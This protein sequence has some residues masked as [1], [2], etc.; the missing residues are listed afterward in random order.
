MR[1]YLAPAVVLAAC[2]TTPEPPTSP[3]A[4]SASLLVAGDTWSEYYVVL[5]G[6]GG[7]DALSPNMDPTTSAA[8]QVVKRRIG[9][10][11]VQRQNLAPG[12]A[13]L[14]GVVVADIRR[15]AN[16]VQV[17]LPEKNAARL[18]GLPGVVGLEEVPIMERTLAS[19]LPVVG[20]P[21][22]WARTTPLT[23][24][25][26]TI[27]IID[28]GV[29]YLH[30]DFGGPGTAQAF[31]SNDPEVIEAGTFPTAKVIGGFDFVGDD[32]NPSGQGQG[33]G[34]PKPDP[35]PIDCFKPQSI[36]VAGGH[37][38]HVAG[39]AAG[40]GVLKSG[41]TFTGPYS[42]SFDPSIF[43][44]APGVAPE[45]KL[46]AL[47]IFGCQGG[48]TQL[49]AALERAVDPN[50]DGNLSDRLDVVNASLGTAYAVGA[51]IG[52]GLVRNLTKAGSLLVVAA[53]NDGQTFWTAGTPSAYPDALS[54]AASVDAD[55]VALQVTSPSSIAGEYAAAE[56]GF[57][58]P[59]NDSG[60][61][62]GSVVASVPANGC[63]NWSNAS[64]VNGK[65]A[66]V[67]R[68]Q[69]T[70][71]QKFGNAI[72]A[73]AVAAIIVDNE[74]DTLPFAMGGGDP[75][76][77]SIPG[78]MIRKVDGT[79]IKAQLSAGVSVTLDPAVKFGGA[80]S[81]IIA[82]FSSRGPSAIDGI[83]KPEISAPGFA[84]DSARVGSGTLARRS[85]GTSMASPVVA[86]A[87]A[88][89]RQAQPG[90]AP[91]AVKAALMNSTEPVLD[92]SLNP[93]PP[94]IAGAGR[95]ALER[96]VDA[97]FTALSDEESSS[98]ALSFG[99]VISDEKVSRDR[100]LSVTNHGAQPIT[101]KLSVDSLRSLPGVTLAI[102]PTELTIAAGQSE[103]AT[104]SLS[105][106]PDAP[107]RPRRG[108][109][110]SRRAVRTTAPLPDGK[111]MAG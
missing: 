91:S 72:K 19:A 10:M 58:T 20:A 26:M 109:R 48:T 74:D 84:I 3:A 42:Q 40:A 52:G 51:T 45:A 54:V 57:T 79:K 81:E 46:Y 61:I 7:I 110:H 97:T 1:R 32:Y 36:Q 6:P 85:Q 87:A 49:A 16:L 76:S 23:G 88:V 92:G 104:L 90:W 71:V 77:V 98:V 44:V 14:G 69:C 8:A 70:F 34:T 41:A 100:S 13:G 29:D 33:G 4:S 93:Y 55:L 15:L 25:G 35:D 9:A 24:S 75:G 30:A 105:L 21:E 94:S 62:S 96:A 89:L 78:V 66:I 103:K 2:S 31:N 28:S 47:K 59:L 111:Q 107:R 67:D 108:P 64:A 43:R 39:I 102:A 27:G 38:T 5:Q 73:G 63:Q 18:K 95:V 17:R 86:G 22:V 50:Q 53:G 106:D 56:G 101:V 82:S 99:A 37:G 68:G 80:G 83:L 60:A 65:V 11:D 12:V